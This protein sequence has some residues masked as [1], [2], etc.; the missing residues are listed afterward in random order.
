MVENKRYL[1]G[2]IGKQTR[3]KAVELR[4]VTVTQKGQ[5]L[6]HDLTLD[7][8][9]GESIAIVGKP[10]A[11][12]SALLA[13][14]QGLIQPTSGQILVMGSSLPPMT[15]KIRRQL[16][17][18]PQQLKHTP[19]DTVADSLRRFASYYALKLSSEQI[20]AYSAHYHFS[21]AT[22]V[23]RLTEVQTRVLALALALL[24]DPRLVLL[25]EP[26][27]D[28]AE[29]DLAEIWGHLQSM[30]R[31]GRTLLSTFTLPV[32]DIHSNGYDMVVTLEQGKMVQR[33][34]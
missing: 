12:K 24:H 2:P 30:Q 15:R 27:S 3:P 33:E 11:G 19:T 31:E 18:L 7:V 20:N 23:A 21:S 17:I 5:T 26:L 6:L 34:R 14:L 28:L 25:D 32:A 29:P 8:F 1:T 22:P 16:G 9:E 4:H 10:G 13:C